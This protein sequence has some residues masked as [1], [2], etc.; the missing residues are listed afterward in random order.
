MAKVS[1]V[2]DKDES[3]LEAENQ[4][5]K[6]LNYHASGDAH[7]KETFHDPAMIDVSMKMEKLHKDMYEEMVDEICELLDEE[8]S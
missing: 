8:Y 7:S 2:L 1:I 5:L 6:A 3:S 4:L